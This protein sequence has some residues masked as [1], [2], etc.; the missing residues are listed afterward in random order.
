MNQ[1]LIA[2]T[3]WVPIDIDEMGN[4]IVRQLEGIY[5][6]TMEGNSSKEVYETFYKEN[7]GTEIIAIS[8]IGE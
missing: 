7:T 3:K 8:Y 5:T 2:Y 4:G 6:T 1:Y